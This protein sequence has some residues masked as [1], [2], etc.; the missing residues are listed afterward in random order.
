MLSGYFYR[1][2][3]LLRHKGRPRA[4]KTKHNRL[5]GRWTMIVFAPAFRLDGK[6]SS[7]EAAACTV[8]AGHGTDLTTRERARSDELRSMFSVF[9]CFFELLAC[10]QVAG[11]K[12]RKVNVPAGFSYTETIGRARPCGPNAPGLVPWVEWGE[13]GGQTDGHTVDGRARRESPALVEG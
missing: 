4:A 2:R 6:T 7:M 12:Y 8:P 13:A 1:P 9:E 11:Q 3:G 5:G 10:R